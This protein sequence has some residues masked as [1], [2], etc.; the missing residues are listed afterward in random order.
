MSIACM[1]VNYTCLAQNPHVLIVTRVAP[2]V[3]VPSSTWLRVATWAS[4]IPNGFFK[5]DP[6]GEHVEAFLGTSKND[7]VSVARDQWQT[8]S[9]RKL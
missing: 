1:I 7:L 4:L 3:M 2:L 8:G 5:C 9:K 6:R